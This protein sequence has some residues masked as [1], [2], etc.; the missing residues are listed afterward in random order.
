MKKIIFSVLTLVVV[1]LVS[2]RKGD[3]DPDIKQYDE[4]QIQNFIKTNGITGM[5]RDT[6]GVYYKILK[7]GTG[8][9]LQYA[10]SINLVF[11]LHTFDGR[12]ASVDTFA[13]H[14]GGFLGHIQKSGYPLAL[15]TSIY[16]L[17][18]KHGGRIRMLIPSH[19]G[20]GA[21]GVGQGSSTT[22]NT[23][24]YGNQCLEYYV[25]VMNRLPGD[26]QN[27]YDDLVIKNYLTANALTG[28]Q[29]TP[30]GIYYQ[31]TRQGVGT[32]PVTDNSTVYCTYT[33]KLLNG[34]I[35]NEYNTAGAGAPLEVPELVPGLREAFKSLATIGTKLTIVLPSSLAY[36]RTAL[37]TNN[38]PANSCVRFDVQVLNVTP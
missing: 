26:N 4:E 12:Y 6:S 23:R 36:G 18:K 22:N 10:D 2:C 14:Y 5:Q 13:N 24:I 31:I 15:Q 17:V 3:V 28:F 32:T 7:E 38:V 35:F 8:D 21:S 11:T 29:K 27:T 33:F 9:A 37:S 20:Y 16:N 1:A 19:L 34:Y 25:N 30:S